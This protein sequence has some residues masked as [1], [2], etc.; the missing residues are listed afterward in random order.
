MITGATGQLGRF[1]AAAAARQGRTVRGY[2]SSQWD[3]GDP[4][5]APALS[6]GDVVVNCAA[7]THVDNAE[8]DSEQA[9]RV[10][11]TGPLNVAR[12]CAEAGARLIHLS[13][14]YVFDGEFGDASARPYEPGDATNPLS[15]YGRSKLDGEQAVLAALPTATVV[16]TAWLYTGGAGQDF[17]AVMARKAAGGESVEVVDDQIG[18]PTYV[19]DLTDVLL[20]LVDG[21]VGAPLLH[22]ADAGAVS[23]FT[24]AQAVYAAVGADPDLV[25]PVGTDRMPRPAR[26][27]AY[28][29]L[30]SRDSV[31]AG[32]VPPRPWS[33]ALADAVARAANRIG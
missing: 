31:A 21:D 17:V 19:A 4:A 10:N 8:S 29:A 30:G 1:L 16:R 11:A 26:R 22:A 12:A 23:R 18:S 3:I 20:Q 15:V 14:D 25:R 2:A 28:S 24:Q 9:F 13:T 33:D 5:A 7:Y 27:P 32:L 6:A